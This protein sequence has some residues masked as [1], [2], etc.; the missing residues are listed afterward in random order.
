[1]RMLF[2]LAAALFLALASASAA[3]L[4]KEDLDDLARISTYLNGIKTLKGRFT[5]VAGDGG[6][7]QGE[8]YLSK[9]GKL[10]FEY[11]PPIPVLI[12]ADGNTI[13]ITNYRL[14]TQDRYPILSTP[15]SLLIEDKVDLTKDLTVTGVTRSPGELSFTAREDDGPAEGEITVV[16]S[17]P[18]LELRHWIVTDAQG[19]QTT[20]SV[21]NL[22]KD[23][24]IAGKLFFIEEIQT[25]GREDR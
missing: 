14:K 6:Y 1:M 21:S 11:E 25:F 7:S 18:G 2:S 15:L 22:R 19:R 24:T 13:A 20:V 12:V 9:P 8:F 3:D 4:S 17:D 10:R 23:E 5:Q 16:F